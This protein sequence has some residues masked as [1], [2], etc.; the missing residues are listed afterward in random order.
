MKNTLFWRL[1][2][3]FMAVIIVVVLVL[4]ST[5]VAVM[6]AQRQN[7]FESEL[8]AQ[9]YEL[10]AV[11]MQRELF[12]FGRFDGYG[13]LGSAVSDRVNT[14]KEEYSANVCLV[15]AVGQVMVFDENGNNAGYLNDERIIGVI[16]RV[17]NGESV[18]WVGQT[19]NSP[20]MMIVVGVPWYMQTG[21]VIMGAIMISASYD[22]LVVDYSDLIISLSFG[23]VLA[24]VL[25]GVLAFVI[26]RTQSKPLRRIDE[27]VHDYA[28]G[29]FDRRVEIKG[30][31]EMERL[32]DSFNSMAEELQRL[33]QSR[34]S[35]VANVSH[36]LRSPMTC[37]QGY[38]QGMLDGTIEGEERDKYLEVVLSE[39]K[40]L[41]NLIRELLDLSRFDSGKMPLNKSQFDINDLLL[42]VMFKYEKRI[43]DKGVEVEITFKQEPCIVEADSERMTQVITNL[44]D[45]A[46]KFVGENG[47]LT[48]WTHV[49][50]RLCYVTIR[51]N[52]APIRQEDLPF[53][54]ERFY[55]ADKA[56][57]SGGGT[58]LGLAIVKRIIEQ[59]GQTINVT[60]NQSHTEFVFTLDY[61][62]DKKPTGG[63]NT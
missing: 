16:K 62:G 29:N 41:T 5:M 60:S 45:N 57:T 49:V 23:A 37:I 20:E 6:R 40:R 53:I 34:K 28:A 3:A 42:S 21:G 26:A 8:E 51:N 25:G 27:A 1:F 31:S 36:E 55:K 19:E 33:D 35:F 38:V 32:A 24:L 7:A 39:T 2:S 47:R 63:Q 56:H 58:G 50:D 46:V 14:L 44:V 17:L 11:L 4:A 54:F 13:G 15:S 30:S 10:N 9:G 12:P 52:G 18:H 61:I 59:H 43:E 48:V 22:S